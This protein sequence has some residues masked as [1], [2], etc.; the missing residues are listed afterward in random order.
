MA[1]STPAQ[2]P[3][4]LAS[5]TSMALFSHAGAAL[6]GPARPPCIGGVERLL[7][8][9]MH[10]AQAVD[11]L[12]RPLEILALAAPVPSGRRAAGDVAHIADLVGKFYKLRLAADL[13]RVLDL[14]RLAGRPRQPLVVG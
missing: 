10:A 11:D 1:R 6:R 2:K 3:R 13:S 9:R 8:A 12:L 7:Q 14:Q 5:R 4:G